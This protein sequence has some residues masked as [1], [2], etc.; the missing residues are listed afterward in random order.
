M[1]PTDRFG[2]TISEPVYKIICEIGVKL[3]GAGYRESVSKPNLFFRTTKDAVYFADMRG[4]EQV[5]IWCEPVPLFYA[6]F[7]DKTPKWLQTRSIKCE[8]ARLD[9]VNVPT[10]QSFYMTQDFGGLLFDDEDGFCR[11]CGRDFQESGAFCSDECK[12]AYEKQALEKEM[13]NLKSCAACGEKIAPDREFS[14]RIKDMFDCDLPVGEIGHHLSYEADLKVVVCKRC[15]N[16]IHHGKKK[17]M[18]GLIPRD[19]PQ[20]TSRKSAKCASCGRRMA[21]QQSSLCRRCEAISMCYSGLGV[22][23]IAAKMGIARSSVRQYLRERDRFQNLNPQRVICTKCK[24]EF[25]GRNRTSCPK[26][27]EFFR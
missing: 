10:R 23:D 27:R 16:R 22:N 17:D 3:V 6:Q 19:R 13:R 20:K 25:D 4:T 5:R 12:R 11:Q 2:S 21:A 7:T 15:H 26:C 18:A 8:I 1:Q 14:V 24:L 9:A